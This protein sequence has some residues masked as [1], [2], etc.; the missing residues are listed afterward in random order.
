MD[1]ASQKLEGVLEWTGR[2]YPFR[3]NV[4][5]EGK[6][7][8][9]PRIEVPHDY[10]GRGTL[11]VRNGDYDFWFERNE[12]RFHLR[13]NLNQL[14]FDTEIQLNHAS[15]NHLDW[16]LL[17]KARFTAL[18]RERG[19]P[20]PRLKGEVRTEYLIIESE[21]LQDFHGSFEVSPEGIQGIDFE[22]SGVFH[23]EGRILFRGGGSRQDLTLQV[24]GY[25]LESIREFALR[26][27]PDNLKGTLEGK[28]KLRG[29]LD[30]PEIQGYFTVK[31]GMIEKLDFDRA[32]I[33]FRGF[34]PQLRL[35]D[36]KVF[37]GRNVLKMTGVIDLRLEN[38]F[39]GIQI[40]RSDH[41]VLWKG[42][43]IYWKEGQS[44]VEADQ[45]LG[46]RLSMG[47]EVG[48]GTPDS[49]SNDSGEE[50]HAVAGPK[51]KF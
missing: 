17:G 31:D 16:V 28:L 49:K 41:L 24:E 12:R 42:M 15:K 7:L 11:D 4:W 29:Q 19:K 25:P 43:S 1:L 32:V 48:G 26:P 50:R 18:R 8:V 21:P 51:L 22:W 14:E 9:L 40:Q 33:E 39:H 5:R 23:L 27:L 34:P 35:Y 3:G 46:K 30:R 38:L 6:K 44:A 10:I 37:R 20:G 36:S 45:P 47:F 2:T 13:S